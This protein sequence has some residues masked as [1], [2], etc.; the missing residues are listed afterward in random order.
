MFAYLKKYHNADMVYD[1]SNPAE[2]K[3]AFEQKYWSSIEVGNVQGKEYLPPNMPQPQR[4]GFIMREKVDADHASD[5]S[6]KRSRM[7]FIASLNCAPV[8]W[9]LKKQTSV[10]SYSFGSEFIAMN[11]CCGYLWVLWYKLRMMGI[12]VECP[13]YILGENQS[14]QENTSIPDS[15]LKNKIQSIPN[16]IIRE[17]ASRN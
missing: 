3:L 1:P 9:I 7:G 13:A 8:Y 4:L 15:M 10:E 14:V 17:G 6:K 16:H 2:E 11:K 5:T 12:P